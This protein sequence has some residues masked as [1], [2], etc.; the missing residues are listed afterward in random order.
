MALICQCIFA[1]TDNGKLPIVKECLASLAET[2]DLKKNRWVII[3]NAS[4]KETEEFLDKFQS[5]NEGNITVLHLKEN[6]GTARGINKGLYS[7]ETGEV[8]IKCDDD[9]TWS[10]R[11]WVKE[12]E[13]QIKKNPD[14]G[15]LGLK[16]DDIWQ[17]PD[18]ENLNYRTVM[19][20]ALEICPDIM[21]TCTAYNPKM[22]DNVGGLSQP[23][24]Y[25][26]D[27]S[28]FSV[29]SMAAGFRNAFLPHIKITN[30]DKGGTEY[31]EWKKR[32]AGEYLTEAGEYMNLIKDGTISYFYDGE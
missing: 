15:I 27:D 21:G 23:G 31:T 22:L 6:I 2:V 26:F 17:R 9:L 1:T 29:R 24:I 25:G 20:G 3:N 18:H 28:I 12:L 30:L 4:S 14:I 5:E 10:V 11:G 13:E 19:Q 32:V 7:R 8:V 16:R